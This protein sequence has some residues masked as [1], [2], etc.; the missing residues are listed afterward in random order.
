MTLHLTFATFC[1]ENSLF[2]IYSLQHHVHI[3]HKKDYD[4]QNARIVVVKHHYQG[5]QLNAKRTSIL[6]YLR[7]LGNLC[8]SLA[9]H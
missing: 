2:T 9:L 3:R 5:C 4:E 6:M 8:S 7:G 1:Q